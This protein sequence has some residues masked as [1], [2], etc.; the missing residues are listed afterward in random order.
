MSVIS[1]LVNDIIKI[2]QAGKLGNFIDYIVFPFYRNM[3]IGS[4]VSFDFPL[5]VFVG[6]NGSGKSSA[7]HAIYGA[8]KG[9]TPYEFWFDT[10]VDPIVYYSD[11][12]M[13]H[14]FYYGYTEN[15]EQKEVIKARIR[16]DA[17]PNYWETSRPLAWAGMRTLKKGEKRKAPVEKNVVYLDFRSELSA[18]DKFFYFGDISKLKSSN[19]QEYLRQRSPIL[20]NLINRTKEYAFKSNGDKINERL[21]EIPNEQMKWI[22]KIL[23]KKYVGGSIIEH[24]IYGGWGYSVVFKTDYSN[25]SEAFAGSGE[26]SVV[27]LV[28]KIMSAEPSSLILLDEPEV[29]LHPGAQEQ[30]KTFLLTQIKRKKH[31][32]IISTH[33]PRLLD[34]LPENAIK[35]FHF[36]PDSK[37]FN[38]MNR[39]FPKEAFSFIGEQVSSKIT[40]IVEDAL[41]KNLLEAV[42][43]SIG[44][45]KKAI[46]DIKFY[47]GGESILKSDWIKFYA[48]AEAYNVF[49]L[50][51]GDQRRSHCKVG[52]LKQDE[53]NKVILDKKIKDQT[54]NGVTFNKDSGDKEEQEVEQ[55]VKYLRFYEKNV[56]YFPC[57]TP[58][59]IVWDN[60][61]AGKLLSGVNNARFRKSL[62]KIRNSKDKF[63]ELSKVLTGND[64]SIETTENIFIQKM[65]ND[66]NKHYKSL[67]DMLDKIIAKI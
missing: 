10:K 41:A 23:G 64:K 43:D 66:G 48:L 65:I 9:Y 56:D 52:E 21:I 26:T 27:R 34:G 47:P 38:I 37:R 42:L 50:F 15:G 5:T 67:C 35:V 16:R 17:N 29:S 30:L 6:H 2:K 11:E 14:S 8:P 60:D 32:I 51:D 62:S 39:V 40:L 49:V 54:G 59:D 22:S 20:H 18:F 36:N 46:F 24:S 61:L 4:R 19:K 44:K 13:R 63:Y 55:R 12:K 7:L 33:S 28:N 58:E 45:G 31:Q 3:G 1:D 53:L 25:Y 57:E